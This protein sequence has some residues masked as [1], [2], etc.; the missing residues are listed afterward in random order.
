MKKA[1]HHVSREEI[2]A[3]QQ[4]VNVGPAMERDFRQLGYED[5]VDLIGED[6]LKMYKELCQLTGVR[7]DPCVLDVFIAV[8]DYMNGNPPANWWEYTAVR[9]QRYGRKIVAASV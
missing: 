6:P 1:D 8:T 3:F 9:K 7:Q 4:I 5:P 2:S